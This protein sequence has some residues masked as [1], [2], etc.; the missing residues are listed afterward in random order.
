MIEIDD[1]EL[2]NDTKIF[3]IDSGD[4]STMLLPEEY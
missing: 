3:V 4:Y 2:G 1:I